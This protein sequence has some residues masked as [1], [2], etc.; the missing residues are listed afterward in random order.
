MIGWIFY[1]FF[2]C[3]ND[4]LTVWAMSVPK[5]VLTFFQ[6]WIMQWGH[7][8]FWI[9][10][11]VFAIGPAFFDR[12]YWNPV[13]LCVCGGISILI[14]LVFLVSEIKDIRHFRKPVK[15]HPTHEGAKSC[16]CCNHQWSLNSFYVPMSP[17]MGSQ[18]VVPRRLD[19]CRECQ[20]KALEFLVRKLDGSDGRILCDY[21]Q[22][23]NI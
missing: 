5:M 19:L 6:F 2:K 21:F 8:I 20:L 3:I 4:S 17:E 1:S 14:P 12:S 10:Q 9:S 11:I 23:F 7:P 22:R 15:L 13:G 16:H 18:L